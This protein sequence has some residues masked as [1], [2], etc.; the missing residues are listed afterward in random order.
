VAHRRSSTSALLG[1]GITLFLPGS[2]GK[3]DIPTL[4]GLSKYFA[5][6]IGAGL[7]HY[8]G[9]QLSELPPAYMPTLESEFKQTLGQAINFALQ[10]AYLVLQEHGTLKYGFSFD[11]EW[12]TSNEEFMGMQPGHT[13]EIDVSDDRVVNI[14]GCGNPNANPIIDV[15]GSVAFGTR[16]VCSVFGKSPGEAEVYAEFRQQFQ[17]LAYTGAQYSAMALLVRPSQQAEIPPSV[18]VP[19]VIG[20]L[21]NL[22]PPSLPPVPPLP[23]LPAAPKPPGPPPLP[24]PL[25]A[26]QLPPIKICSVQD[27][28]TDPACMPK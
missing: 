20:A 23:A 8:G 26:P 28:Q 3:K 21:P 16:I 7:L 19:N 5:N 24:K 10:S 22:P 4:Q 14:H 15:R 12:W 1:Y 25:A 13:Q 17:A 27:A 11:Q 9:R 6:I 2:G 18:P